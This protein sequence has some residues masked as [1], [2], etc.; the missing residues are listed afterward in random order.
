[1][2]G[3]GFQVPDPDSSVTGAGCDDLAVPGVVEGVDV[4]LMSAEGVTNN[5]VVDV[6][7]LA[8]GFVSNV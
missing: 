3:T 8:S 5:F 6:P 7:N 4:L 2:A 1:M